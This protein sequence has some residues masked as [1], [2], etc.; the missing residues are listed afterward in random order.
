M[1]RLAAVVGPPTSASAVLYEPAHG[2]SD[3]AWR[4]RE[5]QHGHVNVD[6][7]AVAWWP[8]GE[9]RPRRYATVATPWADA[10]LAALADT[11]VGSPIV[12]AVRGATPGVGYGVALVSPF[13][14]E[15]VAFAHNGSLSHWRGDVGRELMSQVG[16]HGWEVQPGLSD[17]RLLFGLIVD[18]LAVG[19]SV[20]EAT[21][22]VVAQVAKHV[23]VTNDT[24]TLNLLVATRDQVVATRASVG[25]AGNSLHVEASTHETGVARLRLASEPLDDA[26]WQPV[27][28][29]T[30]VS[31]HDGRIDLHPLDIQE[32]TRA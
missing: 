13:V 32:L 10:N 29:A 24:A 21:Q 20:A 9:T 31:L 28:E 22:R 2:L 26:D 8:A 30:L 27:P 23:A 19:H 11:F 15:H 3:Q 18:Q 17:S 12:A 14:H 5:Q 4:P 16:A 1:C 25:W 6:G 7:T